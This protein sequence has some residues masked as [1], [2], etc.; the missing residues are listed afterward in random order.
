MGAESK[1]AH[2][3]LESSFGIAFRIIFWVSFVFTTND[4][5]PSWLQFSF[6][7]FDITYFERV[8]MIKFLSSQGLEDCPN[9]P[10]HISLYSQE[11]KCKFKN[12]SRRRLWVTERPWNKHETSKGSYFDGVQVHLHTLVLA[13]VS[14]SRCAMHNQSHQIWWLCFSNVHLKVHFESLFKAQM[15]GITFIKKKKN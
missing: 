12:H 8:P 5:N 4:I 11:S 13:R 9:E 1:W 6:T 15:L 2:I 3:F 10:V 14:T 7:Y